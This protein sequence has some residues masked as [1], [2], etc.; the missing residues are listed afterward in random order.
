MKKVLLTG[1][2]SAGKSSLC[3]ALAQHFNAPVVGEYV[4]QYIE[5]I[6]RDTHYADVE[7]IAREQWQR[8]QDAC[9]KR[10]ALV[11]LDTNLLSN[12]QWSRIL[13]GQSPG[14]ID[15][16]LAQQHYDAVFLLS[17][18]GLPWQAD[19]QRCQPELADRQAF[20]EGLEHWLLQH[21]QPF[22]PVSGPWDERY[23]QLEAA[24]ERL[25]MD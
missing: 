6:G 10:P 4:R 14:W 17:P 20:H 21:Q 8:E 2:E 15:P 7:I 12:R 1:P 16:L 23:Q 11:L 24:I 9:A 25:L 22:E 19:G 13:F 5:Q 3:A 18:D